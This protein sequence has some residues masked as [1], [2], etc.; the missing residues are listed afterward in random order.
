MFIVWG[1]RHGGKCYVCLRV[2]SLRKVY[3]LL[4]LYTQRLTE[5]FTQRY[6]NVLSSKLLIFSFLSNS[7]YLIIL[8]C[9]YCATSILGLAHLTVEV[10]KANEI[11][12]TQPIWFFGTKHHLP[13]EASTYTKRNTHTQPCP[14][15]IRTRYRTNQSAAKVHLRQYGHWDRR[16]DYMI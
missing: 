2:T 1:H 15:R 13:A 12:Q 5:K 8:F 4:L 10:Y 16:W 9:F 14:C 3:G 6:D 7:W 11:R